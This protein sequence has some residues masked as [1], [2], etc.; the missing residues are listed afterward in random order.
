MRIRTLEL[1]DTARVVRRK[2]I[3]VKRSSRCQGTGVSL[4]PRVVVCSGKSRAGE[5]VLLFLVKDQRLCFLLEVYYR[6]RRVRKLSGMVDDGR[7]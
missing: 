2:N 6:E 7:E 5:E 3:V 4:F 1:E